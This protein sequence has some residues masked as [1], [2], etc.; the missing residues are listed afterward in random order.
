LIALGSLGDPAAIPGVLIVASDAAQ[1]LSERVPYVL[2]RL[3]RAEQFEQFISVLEHGEPS[4]RAA[5]ALA[6]GLAG[7]QR[8]QARLT[9]ALHDPAGHVRGNAALALGLLQA[10]EAVGALQ[11]VADRDPDPEVREPASIGV[12]LG[13]RTGGMIS[14]LLGGLSDTNPRVRVFAAQALGLLQVRAAVPVLGR[15]AARD[16]DVAV[17]SEATLARLRITEEGVL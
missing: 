10:P 6:L 1:R 4:A 7:E 3:Y 17:R 16:T 14:R 5:V 11:Q 9:Q 2:L 8:A 13:S 12:A 15:L